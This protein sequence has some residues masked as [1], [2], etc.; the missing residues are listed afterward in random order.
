MKPSQTM[1]LYLTTWRTEWARLSR[2]QLA[3]LVSSQLQKPGR[4]TVPILRQWEA[5]QPPKELEEL[6]ALCQVMRR[7]GLLGSEVEHFRNAV[8]SA[9]LD[10][11]Y[12]G[13]FADERLSPRAEVEELLDTR[14]NPVEMLSRL[15]TLTRYVQEPPLQP[16]PRTLVRHWQ[17]AR[18]R[19]LAGLAFWHGRA[20]RTHMAITTVRECGRTLRSVSGPSGLDYL[21]SP[22][23][24]QL[25]ELHHRIFGLDEPGAA[26]LMLSLAFDFREQGHMLH[27]ANAL[28]EAMHALSNAQPR[29]LL[30]D[31]LRPQVEAAPNIVAQQSDP[32]WVG[33]SHY[34][35]CCAL[36]SHGELKLAEAH[37]PFVEQIR[38]V[39]QAAYPWTQG[40]LAY[41]AG[42][43]EEAQGNFTRA[44][45]VSLNRDGDWVT[46]SA[47]EW[48][49]KCERAQHEVRHRGK[50]R[51]ISIHA[52]AE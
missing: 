25:I 12:E 17:E 14:G 46:A 30:Y 8:F 7:H 9:C 33:D 5:G 41:A 38:P 43:Y 13:L 49:G 28:F 3:L 36:I 23:Q 44:H 18:C 39:A 20:G 21:R 37:L 34:A 48:L 40:R 35:L 4:V 10:R 15:H 45:A 51:I 11:H 47:L 29:R 16:C 52:A 31:Q 24:M 1:G 6:E 27:Y 19:L 2:A 50:G 22:A 26:G 32:L 42:Q